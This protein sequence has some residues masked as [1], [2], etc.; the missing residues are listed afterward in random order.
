MNSVVTRFALIEPE[1]RFFQQFCDLTDLLPTQILTRQIDR[2]FLAF[3]VF[4][5]CPEV[6]E[7]FYSRGAE[8][9]DCRMNRL[10]ARE[11]PR[12]RKPFSFQLITQSLSIN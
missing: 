7:C 8:P 2:K 5:V 11:L 10:L 6:G 12:Y 3:V 9:K 1:Q 4:I